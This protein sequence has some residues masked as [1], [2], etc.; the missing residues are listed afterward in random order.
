MIDLGRVRPGRT[1]NIPFGS[2]TA[3]TGASSGTT[4]YAAGD[5]QIYKATGG[6]PSTTQRGSTSG[7]TASTDFD[8]QTGI[9]LV[10]IDLSDN[11]T[12]GFYTAG[13]EYIVVIADVTIDSQT[14]RFPIARFTI[15]YTDA[16][17]DTT[18]ATLSSQTS[19]TLTN[20]S[21][22]NSAYVGSD[23]YIHAAASSIQCCM[24]TISAYTGSTK[25][26]TLAVSPGIY[27]IAAGDNISIFHRNNTY[28]FGGT[29]QT[30]RDVGLALWTSAPGTTGGAPQ[31]LNAGTLD[32]GSSTTATIPAAFTG[33]ATS[34]TI[35]I[36]TGGKQESRVIT[37]YN[38]GT[39]VATFS[40]LVTAATNASTY[41]LFPLGILPITDYMNDSTDL[42]TIIT[43]I[44]AARDNINTNINDGVDV[45]SLNADTTAVVNLEK[46]VRTNCRGTVGNASTTTSLITSAFTP[47]GVHS[48]Q[49][50]GR[51]VTFDADTTT[52]ALRGQATSISASSAAATPVLT[53]VALTDAP[54]SGDTFSVT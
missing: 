25:T 7:I 48:G 30:A 53:V 38:S 49:F 19:F 3:S 10:T 50:I 37:A 23:V 15:G 33:D 45:V 21:A 5:V 8:S 51:I 2:Y 22:D 29:V 16:V 11:A 13:S 24:G 34:M 28:T 41:V 27:T 12:S 32:A 44:D 1:I 43:E 14:V 46:A 18:I 20:G 4:N 26:V 17:V 9:N 35:L 36:S 39:R 54:V 6:V 47:A 40:T 52:T 31:V 42:S